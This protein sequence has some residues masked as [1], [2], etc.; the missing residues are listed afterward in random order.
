MEI[1]PEGISSSL[2]LDKR[3]HLPHV[4]LHS[5]AYRCTPT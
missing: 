4:R 5:Y 2:A 3:L 1:N